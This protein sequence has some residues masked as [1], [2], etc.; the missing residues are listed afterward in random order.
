M[1]QLALGLLIL[2]LSP[3]ASAGASPPQPPTVITNPDWVQIPNGE[4][5]ADAYPPVA[6]LI[7]LSGRAVMRCEV[8][9]QGATVNCSI[10]S[11]TPVGMGFGDAALTLSKQFR[12]KPMTRNGVAVDDGRIRIP[13]RFVAPVS[14]ESADES[15]QV[16]AAV[17]A[18]A[19]QPSPKALA[20]GRKLATLSLNPD[21]TVLAINTFRAALAHQFSGLSLTEQQKAAIDDYAQAVGA[22]MSAR[23]EATAESYARRLSEKQLADADAFFES[24]SGLAWIGLSSRDAAQINT[25]LQATEKADAR[26]RFCGQ[27][28]CL[29]DALPPAPAK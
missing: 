23:I 19:P 16:K 24:P 28:T 10:E 9:A 7:G 21:Q 8:S 6:Q 4:D 20:L 2:I 29:P 17:E 11:E 15:P 27:F 3:A 12:M 13:I 5:M 14:D 26:K 22:S 25:D 1:R 18:L